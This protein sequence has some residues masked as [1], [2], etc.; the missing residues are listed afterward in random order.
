[1]NP[2]P[3]WLIGLAALWIAMGGCGRG[4]PLASLPV[5]DTRGFQGEVRERIE[6]AGRDARARPED[7]DAVARL[8][9]TLHA[10]GQYG[11]AAACYERA[12]GLDPKRYEFAYYLGLV[13]AADGNYSGAA[14]EFRRAAA[15]KADSTPAQL[16]LGDA[17]LLAGDKSG[18]QQVYRRIL[19]SNK[20]V[21]AAHYGLGRTLTGADAA[22]EFE[23]TLELFP[24]YGAARFALAA[25][26]RQAGEAGK[27]RDAMA[28]YERDKLAVPPLADP[29]LQAVLDLD[30]SANGLLRQARNLDREGRLAEALA[31]HERAVSMDPKLAQAYVNMI[32][33]YG[34]SERFGEAE[35]AY[36]KAIALAPG[37]GE[38]YYNFGVLCASQEKWKP[39]QAAFEKAV[40]LEPDHAEAW[41]NL[42]TVV[43]RFG[44]LDRAAGYFEEAIARKPA[45]QSAHFHLGRIFAN[46]RKYLQA[47]AEMEKSLEP[48]GENTAVFLYALASVHGRAG[49]RAKAVELMGQARE[50]AAARGMA[51]VVESIDRDL[52]VL[53]ARR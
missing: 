48:A 34:R 44:Q 52:R 4:G 1:M 3:P 29:A 31:L 8:G 22:R 25:V 38:A 16:A 45:Y 46:Q 19:D 33:L 6:S 41:H 13:R 18:A 36:R 50:Q 10:H 20:D 14:A 7:A 27:A 32:S 37:Q 51:A 15:L 9:M 2:A 23:R 17:L 5:V 40:E 26:Y 42:G 35:E 30:A 21:A 43:E 39:A 47:I 53:G 11:A 28:N 24:R 12:G 49:H